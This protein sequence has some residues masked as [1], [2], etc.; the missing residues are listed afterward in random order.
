MVNGSSKGRI[1]LLERKLEVCKTKYQ[2]ERDKLNKFRHQ[3]KEIRR[4]V[5][6]IPRSL[7]KDIVVKCVSLILV[8]QKYI[9]TDNHETGNKVTEN[10]VT[11][12]PMSLALKI[13]DLCDG[14]QL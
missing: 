3:E 14:T 5:N 9:Q 6:N 7:F 12:I 8:V 11:Y 13:H 10:L 4:L 2:L 1:E